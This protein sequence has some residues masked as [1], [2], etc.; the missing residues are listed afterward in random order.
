MKMQMHPKAKGV[1]YRAVGAHRLNR[2]E[3]ASLATFP[4]FVISESKNGE[5]F[6]LCN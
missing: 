2:K 6:A 3:D 5:N 4:N 1:R